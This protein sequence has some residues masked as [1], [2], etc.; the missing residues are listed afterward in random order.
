MN[1]QC[2]GCGVLLQDENVLNIGYTTNLNNDYCERCFR[3]KNYGEYQ[4]VDKSDEEFI[5]ILKTIN[6]TN[7]LVVYVV[8]ILNIEEDIKNIRNYINNKMI[9][10]INKKDCLPK[11]V[12]DSKLI[13]YFKDLDIFEEVI[14]VSAVK[15]YNIDYLLKRIKYYQISKDVY[16]IGYTNAGKS[17]L[18]NKIMTNY[19]ETDASLSISSLPTTTLNTLTL[20]VDEHLNLIDTPGIVSTTNITNF[21]G[22]EIL[23][24]INP[25]KEIKPKT[26]QIRKNQAII[27]EDLVRIDYIEGNRNSF[28]IFVSNDL[29]IKRLLNNRHDDLK[30]LDMTEYNIGYG[31]DLV[32][33]GLGFI[34]V[35]E[36]CKVFIYIDKNIKVYLRKSLI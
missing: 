14:I 34:K 23:K 19:S 25:K 18:I 36:A 7:D 24:K 12:K 26:Y 22:T 1:K 20:K 27:I 31:E 35:I 2:L 13:D 33:E 6:K 28:T 17:T 5:N 16:I 11:S 30:D 10:V 21:I 8:D 15:N 9:L 32:I 4:R 29:K 3:L